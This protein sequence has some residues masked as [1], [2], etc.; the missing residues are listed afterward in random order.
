MHC[1]TRRRVCGIYR[2]QPFCIMQEKPIPVIYL[3]CLGEWRVGILKSEH[4]L[5]VRRESFDFI[6]HIQWD[7]WDF[8]FQFWELPL[9]ISSWS[10]SRILF[11]LRLSHTLER[12]RDVRTCQYFSFKSF[13]EQQI[14]CA[15]SVQLSSINM[16]N[17]RK[18]IMK[19]TGL[20]VNED[21][22]CDFLCFF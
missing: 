9:R 16:K 13:K 1:I 12:T 18:Y 14:E 8:C 22:R 21:D 19:T 10:K 3:N 2:K 6:Q 17:C 4:M 11:F 15:M 7:R 5:D 20:P